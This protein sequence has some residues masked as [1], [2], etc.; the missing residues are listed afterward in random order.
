MTF[1]EHERREVIATSRHA[2]PSEATEVIQ[3]TEYVEPAASVDRVQATAYDPYQPR[4]RAVERLIAAIW[5]VFGLIEGLILIRFLLRALGANPRADFADFVYRITT[6]LLL[7]FEGLFGNPRFDGAVL[8]L[9][10]LVAMVIYALIGWLVTK[11]AWLMFG[12]TRSAVATSATSVD[13][14]IR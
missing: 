7:P 10:A 9:H 13:T 1:N 8:E 14:R 4:R 11:I 5:L 6:P 3:T 12:E 2:R